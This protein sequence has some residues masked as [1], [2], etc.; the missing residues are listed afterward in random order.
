MSI[1]G[2]GLAA[3]RPATSATTDKRCFIES[4][5]RCYA[6]S[7]FRK[8]ASVEAQ[9][10]ERAGTSRSRRR[11]RAGPVALAT[12]RRY[13]LFMTDEPKSQAATAREARLQAALRENLKRR[14]AQARARS[15]QRD[16]PDAPHDSA[17]IQ[18]DKQL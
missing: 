17:G 10:G 13:A 7:L 16:K 5:H 4:L 1:A 9:V 15:E 11:E 3:A 12:A 18:V 6:A 8:R 2:A 14:K